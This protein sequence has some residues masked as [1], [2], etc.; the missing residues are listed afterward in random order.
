MFMNRGRADAPGVEIAYGCLWVSAA[1]LAIDQ[2][3]KMAPAI[4]ERREQRLGFLARPWWA[5]FSPLAKPLIIGTAILIAARSAQSEDKV[6]RVSVEATRLETYF[7]I[8]TPDKP[9][10]IRTPPGLV[11]NIYFRNIGPENIIGYAHNYLFQYPNEILSPNDENKYMKIVTSGITQD[12]FF[13]NEVFA[14][15]PS[16]NWFRAVDSKL[17]LNDWHRIIGGQMLTYLFFAIKYR[18]SSYLRTTERCI[19]IKRNYPSVENCKDHNES[20][21]QR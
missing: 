5:S 12:D 15:A 14:E 2:G 20:F 3:L 4:R 19:Y 6:K 7:S 21:T 17:T 18:V 11:V 9:R 8:I 16:Y 13:H 1:I 10:P